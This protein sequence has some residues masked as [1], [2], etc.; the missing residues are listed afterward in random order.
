MKPTTIATA[1]CLGLAI[2]GAAIVSPTGGFGFSL[3]FLAL[4]SLAACGIA[5]GQDAVAGLGIFSQRVWSRWS[6]WLALLGLGAA[7]LGAALNLLAQYPTSSCSGSTCT[8]PLLSSDR[9]NLVFLGE[10]VAAGGSVLL[11]LA[12]LSVVW[13]T[14]PG[15]RRLKA[16]PEPV[17]SR[18]RPKHVAIVGA[19]LFILG[20]LFAFTP[21][22]RRVQSSFCDGMCGIWEDGV[23]PYRIPGTLASLVGTLL[24][25]WVSVPYVR[26]FGRADLGRWRAVPVV[27]LAVSVVLA[28]GLTVG[29]LATTPPT[30]VV[31]IPAGSVFHFDRANVSWAYFFNVTSTTAHVTGAWIASAN[32][33]LGLYDADNLVKSIPFCSPWTPGFTPPWSTQGMIDEYV[34]PWVHDALTMECIVPP[35]TLTITQAIVVSAV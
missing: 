18:G 26:R 17:D 19:L 20:A 14:S 5:L 34:P 30:T 11:G 10:G 6:T 29:V 9:V 8:G 25:T 1:V 3:Q 15:W 2:V 21:I 23:F 22:E 4:L 7:G 12:A 16:A 27:L 24:L 33:T 13:E 32:V 31:L 35:V 28:V